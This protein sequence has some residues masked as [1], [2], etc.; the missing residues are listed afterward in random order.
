LVP[1][2]VAFRG[3][4]STAGAQS[5]TSISNLQSDFSVFSPVAGNSAGTSNGLVNTSKFHYFF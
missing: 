2:L 4:P 3:I 5:G 1:S